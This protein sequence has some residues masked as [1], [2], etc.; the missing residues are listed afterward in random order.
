MPVTEPS[1]YALVVSGVET[2]TGQFSLVPKAPRVVNLSSDNRMQLD[3]QGGT[4]PNN[5]HLMW[6]PVVAFSL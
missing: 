3:V 4:V 6:E 1:S 5:Y 2:A